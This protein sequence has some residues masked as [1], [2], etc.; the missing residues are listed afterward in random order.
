MFRKCHF[1]DLSENFEKMAS[2]LNFGNL[3]KLVPTQKL[4]QKLVKSSEHRALIDVNMKFLNP[5]TKV[6]HRRLHFQN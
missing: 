6:I 5:P 1:S 2:N 4:T 3:K